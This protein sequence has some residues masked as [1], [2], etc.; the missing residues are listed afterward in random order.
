MSLK[1]EERL[2]NNTITERVFS[3]YTTGAKVTPLKITQNGEIRYV[4]V[5]DEFVEDTFDENGK[6]CSPN[7]YS[8]DVTGLL[9]DDN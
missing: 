8:T 4:W 7:I 6:T 2:N 9:N 5:V 3:C 1:I